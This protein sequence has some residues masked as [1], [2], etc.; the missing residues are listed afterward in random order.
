MGLGNAFG[1]DSYLKKEFEFLIKKFRIKNIVET[2]TFKGDTTKE[3]S[4]IVENVYSIE[5][6]K[7]YYLF[8]KKRL[9]ED[10]NIKLFLGSSPIILKKI[11]PALEG[12]TLFFL[13]AHWGN[14]WPILDELNE[15]SKV[16]HM[17]K[18]V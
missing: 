1:G 16:N 14:Y 15:I 11:L 18:S 6:N 13:D 9:K 2:G 12:N 10:N 5:S 7:K 8:S 3:F 17:K 4:K